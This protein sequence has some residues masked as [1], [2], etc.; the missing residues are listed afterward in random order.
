MIENYKELKAKYLSNTTFASQTDTE[1][2]VQLV[3]RFVQTEGMTTK[4]AFLKTLSLLEGSS[5]AFLLMDSTDPETLYVAKNKSPLLIGV[6]DGCNVVCSDALAMLNVTHDFLE[7]HDG[8][9]VTIKPDSVDIED[10]DGNKVERKSFHVNMDAQETDKGPYPYYMLKEIDEQPNVMRKLASLYTEESGKPN[11]DSQ[12]INAMKEADR[13]YIVGAGT[14]YHAGLVGK[15]LFEKLAHVPTEVH[16]ASE[17]AYDNPLLSK[18]P[19]FIFLSQSGETADSRE[20]LVNVNANNYESLT[21]TNVENS[22]LFREA[23]YTMLLHAGPEISVASTKAY[24]AQIGVEAIL[25]K[26]LGEAKE[27]TIAEEFDIRQ[28]LGLVATG[29]QAIIDE[30]DLIDNLAKKYF[31]PANRAF[32]IGRGIDQTVSLE[33]ALKLKEISYVQAE[34]FAS[35]ELKHGT[36]AL[37]EEGT[38]VVGIITQKRTANLTRSNLQET[39]SRGAATFTIVRNGLA[40]EGDTLVIPDVNELITPLLSVVPAQLIAYFTSLNKGLDVDRP[41]NLAKSVTVE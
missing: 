31:V 7:L 12:L 10:R 23:T 15:K 25:A 21:I 30:K 32:Y 27:Q 17:F 19:F 8:E 13:L 20:V 24:T 5:Y 36:I 16:I 6:G 39:E 37:I 38:P 14:S 2:V 11:V 41:R 35:G 40:Q 29:M 1:V 33:S 18:K 9:V 26:A 22:T 4:Q 28:Q 34:G 3:D